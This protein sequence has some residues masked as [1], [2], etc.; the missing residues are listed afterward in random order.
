MPRNRTFKIPVFLRVIVSGSILILILF[1]VD[2][3]Q[4]AR[5]LEGVDF[6]FFLLALL[7]LSTQYLLSALKWK[8]ILKAENISPPF[9]SLLASYLIGN[10]LSLFLPSS[11]GGDIYRVAALQRFNPNI[12]QNTSSVLF[13]RISGFFALISIAIIGHFLLFRSIINYY[14]IGGYAT[15]IFGFLAA[16][17]NQFLRLEFLKKSI[18]LKPILRIAESF[19]NYR[20]NMSILALIILISFLFQNNIVIINKLYCQSLGIHVPLTYLYVI[21]PI[22]YLTEA[23]PITINGLGVREGAFIVLFQHFG[24]DKTDAVALALLVITVRY[25]LSLILGGGLTCSMLLF[26]RRDRYS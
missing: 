19:N 9:S 22:V 11:F 13:D 23:V 15:L 26:Q 4:I 2:P 7:V 17:S 6:R 3:S 5:R 25:A 16:T 24:Y 14:L 18:F 21:I 8:I 20:R 12:Y 1:H 10:F